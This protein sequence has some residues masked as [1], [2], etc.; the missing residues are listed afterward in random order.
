MSIVQEN[1]CS[2]NIQLDR[3]QQKINL[4]EQFDAVEA[5]SHHVHRLQNV[6]DSISVTSK[7]QSLLPAANLVELLSDPTLS[8]HLLPG[9]LEVKPEKYVPDYL[10][11]V[12]AKAAVQASG[13][14]MHTLLGQTIQ[15]QEEIYYWDE[16]LGSVWSSG[17]YAAQTS[18][19]RLWHWSMDIYTDHRSHGDFQ[20]SI[21]ESLAARWGQFYQ[22]ARQSLRGM[23]EHPGTL[24]WSLPIRSCRAEIRQKRDRLIALKDIHTSSLGLIMEHWHAFQSDDLASSSNVPEQWQEAVSKT[25]HL[26]EAI[27]QHVLKQSD[28]EVFEQYVFQ[29]VEKDLTSVQVQNY[30]SSPTHQ[31]ADLIQ[32]LILVLREQLPTHKTSIT[33]SI[34]TYGRP[35]RF[36]RYWLPLSVALLSSSI[37]LKVLIRRQDEIIDWI[38]NIGSTIIDFGGNWVIRPV[39][40]LIG[41][42]RHDDK[43]EIAIM[44]KNSLM[45]DRASLERMVI[46]FVR[47]RPDPSQGKPTA[48]S[49]AAIAN[50]VKEGDLTPVLKAYERDLRA[51]FSGT[52]RGD[53]VRALLIQIQKTKV[54]VEIA[55]SGINALLKSQELVFGFIGLTPGILVSYTSL[56][57]VAGLFSNRRGLRQGKKRYQLRRGLRNVTRILTSASVT[58]EVISYK[59]S[60][61]LICEAE[62]LLQHV[63]TVLG[64]LEYREF[65]EDI[66]DLL[67]IQGGVTKQLR[68]VERIR[69]T[70]FN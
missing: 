47:D 49:T 27:L 4:P 23:S 33:M 43:S 51:P 28:T 10:W 42:I 68:V 55:I 17:L 52:V 60:G 6:I 44:S 8:H 45:A 24:N 35:S 50:A 57:W 53:L 64:G 46:D 13:L 38:R 18:P 2:L 59:D 30:G 65:R 41:T 56:Q 66:E 58:N 69:W 36:M 14:V 1:A 62:A 5:P 19:A 7:T 70:Y 21:S 3:L 12:A 61:R 32:R 67:D 25:V 22:V 48:E 16:V 37:S 11:L 39:Q 40:K 54:D 31:P 26:T 29:D 63:K 9:A 34:G 20:V 15:L